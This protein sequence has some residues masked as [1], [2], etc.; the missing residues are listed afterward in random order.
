MTCN[1]CKLQARIDELEDEVRFLQRE[2]GQ[3]TSED[4]VNRLSEHMRDTDGCHRRGAARVV[5]LLWEAKSK[6]VDRYTLLQAIPPKDVTAD[7]LER[8]INIIS[9]WISFARK[10]LG[11]G[12]IHTI[13]GKGYALTPEGRSKVSAILGDVVAPGS[14]QGV[15]PGA[16]PSS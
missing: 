15:V 1:C 13:M 11:V 12:S 14:G 4:V 8:S 7:P 3:A 5:A 6:Y 10:S 9:V 16:D 2:L